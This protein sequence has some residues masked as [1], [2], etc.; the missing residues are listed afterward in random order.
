MD[1]MTFN[2]FYDALCDALTAYEAAAD[3]KDKDY[4]AGYTLYCDIVSIVGSMEDYV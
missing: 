2:N 4:D 3:N 1:R